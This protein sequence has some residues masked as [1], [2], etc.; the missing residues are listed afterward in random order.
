MAT[1][2]Q[3]NDY[4]D[5]NSV[6]M[7]DISENLAPTAGRYRGQTVEWRESSFATTDLACHGNEIWDNVG[8]NS[9]KY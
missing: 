9:L 3:K 8:N 2:F 1:N 7:I 4:N 6:C 5:Y